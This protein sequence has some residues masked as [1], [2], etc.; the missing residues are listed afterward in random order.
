MSDVVRSIVSAIREELTKHRN[1]PFLEAAMA[2][3][4]YVAM[5][6]GK[7]SFSERSRLDAIL[8]T[9]ET[10][11]IYDPHDAVDL[12]NE[13]ASELGEDEA[14]ARET[15]F[16]AIVPFA[17]AT[18]QATLL[19]RIG[20]AVAHADGMFSDAECGRLK[21]ICRALGLPEA[22]ATSCF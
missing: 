13:L 20:V 5:A 22:D 21:E 3:A 15:V 11:R 17:K 4:A 14:A 1:K 8:E 19:L 6:D 7:V 18:A 9:I 16:E 2:V 10:L 12:F